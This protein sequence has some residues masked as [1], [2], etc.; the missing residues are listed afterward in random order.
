M[1]KVMLIGNVGSDPEIRYTTNGNPVGNFS[2]ATSESWNSKD[3]ERQEKTEWHKITVWGKLAEIC[4]EYLSK[5][6]Q[7]YVE[8]STGTRSYEGDDGV[9]KYVTEITAKEVKFLGSKKDGASPG[10]RDSIPY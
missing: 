4:G 7:V 5:G 10:G 8:G 3:G 9:K 1:N 2:V 6:R